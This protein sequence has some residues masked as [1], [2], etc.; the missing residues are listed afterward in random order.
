MIASRKYESGLISIITPAH[1]AA[2]Y[3]EE[4]LAT[5]LDQTYGNW[6]WLIVDDGSTD[7]T[8][9]MVRQAAVKDDRIRLLSVKGQT[10]SA[11]R[12]RNM[13]K[14]KARGEFI[15]YLDAD[16]LWE[17]TK[18]E[19]Q[20]EYLRIHPEVAGVCCWYDLFGDRER[21]ARDHRIMKTD[22]I[23]HRSEILQGSPF[24]TPTILFRRSCYDEMGGMDE[25]PRLVLGEDYEYFARL[26]MNYEFHRLR[27]V[28]VHVRVSPPRVSLSSRHISGDTL[29]GISV[30]EVLTE[31]GLLTPDE[32]RQMRS[33]MYYTQAGD[34]LFQHHAPFRRLLWRSI[35][36][37]RPPAKALIMFALS[38]LPD[39]ALRLLLQWLQGVRKAVLHSRVPKND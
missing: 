16:D 29:K 22:T 6:E 20:V 30:L 25:D 38:P 11:A 23:C 24:P 2:P 39:P 4:T 36:T 19:Y 5:V 31:K 8:A 34:N 32:Q 13:G 9:D 28:L 15:A 37:G 17:I 26:I 3:F 18:N 14:S 1:N 12:A 35:L 7:N 33:F 27:E 10:G 21:I